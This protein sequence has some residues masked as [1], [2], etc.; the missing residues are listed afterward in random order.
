MRKVLKLST[1]VLMST[2]AVVGC[3]KGMSEQEALEYAKEQG[4]RNELDTQAAINYAKE[5]GYS[6]ELDTEEA[7][8][9]A[10]NQG[11]SNE[12]DVEEAIEY[13]ISQGYSNE[14]DVEE[15]IEYAISQGY[16]NELDVEEAIEYAINHG[17]VYV[18]P[19]QAL[20]SPVK[21]NGTV[22]IKGSEVAC[23]SDN[24]DARFHADC[25]SI[26]HENL[27]NYL[28][29][30]DVVYIDLREA[31]KSELD[32][33]YDINDYFG[34]HLKG[35]KNIEFVSYIQGNKNQ[36]FYV[37]QDKSLAPRY[38]TSLEILEELFSKDK[39]IFLMCESGN[40]ARSV[41][42][43]LAQYGWDMNK[44]Y[45]VGASGDYD[46]AAYEDYLLS[47]TVFELK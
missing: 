17:Y 40:K 47:A 43:L 21:S 29:R 4:Y 24:L 5:Q 6:N 9:Y 10:I 42:K 23:D 45:N 3:S 31:N 12:L 30:D 36:L 32:A 8:E 7:I 34:M 26:N 35:F 39:A 27:I 25:S 38:T 46:R 1:L 2:L 33:G 28:G 22:T 14:L 16:S 41:M 20:P 18:T 13:A 11:Y 37:A 44:V 19:L 15:A